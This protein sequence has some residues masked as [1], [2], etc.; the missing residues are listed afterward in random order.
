M[1]AVRLTLS[2]VDLPL[3][4]PGHGGQIHVHNLRQC[5]T[6]G[7][8][9]QEFRSA[10]R[11]LT[12]LLSPVERRVLVWIAE[13]LPR[14]VNSDHLT[15]VALAAMAGAGLSYA[16]ARQSPFWLL[17][18][19]AC[20]ALN[21]FG[22]SLDGTL[23]RVRNCQRP[24][25]GF[26]VDH[27]V[28]AVGALFLFSGLALSGFMSPAIAAVLLVAYLLLLVETFLAT[29]VLGT[30]KMSHFGVGPTELRLILATG[31]VSLLWHPLAHFG[32]TTF[33]MFDVGGCIGAVGLATTF[34][35]SVISH[36]RRL[37]A[38]EPVRPSRRA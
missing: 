37:Y 8:S 25:Y 6:V 22:D 9:P 28:D 38:I 17:G 3:R 29:H 19:N 30:F 16:L 11:Q 18:V 24:R 35:R 27:V 13:R 10:T 34:G 31:N 26:Y 1:T 20:L 5:G 15:A 7:T 36:T 32:D 23:A 4:I 33:A 2:P 12:S 21:W 14:I